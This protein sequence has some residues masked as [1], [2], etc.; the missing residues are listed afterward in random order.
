VPQVFDIKAEHKAP[1]I[2]Q[3]NSKL[4]VAED[5]EARM[6][7]VYDGSQKRLAKANTAWACHHA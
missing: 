7:V 6:V 2:W 4:M 1:D 5:P 3:G